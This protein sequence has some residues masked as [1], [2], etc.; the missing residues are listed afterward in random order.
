M[1][2]HLAQPEREVLRRLYGV[3]I[4]MQIQEH[5]LSQLFGKRPITQIMARE[6]E[7]HSLVLAHNLLESQLIAE[8][9]PIQRFIEP[10]SSCVIQCYC[11]FPPHH[12][13]STQHVRLSNAG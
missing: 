2:G 3:M 11:S 8:G 9:R 12:A 5:L 6:T 13:I 7:D 4:L 1:A 10:G